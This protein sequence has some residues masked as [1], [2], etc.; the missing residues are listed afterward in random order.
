M[1]YDITFMWNL[2]YDTNDLFMKQKQHRYRA[3]TF[4][5]QVGG[6]WGRN[7]VGGWAGQMEALY[8]GQI[9][10]KVLLYGTENHI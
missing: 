7:G 10:N 9:N 2:K 4:G 8:M 1:P 3:Q 5:C 6:G